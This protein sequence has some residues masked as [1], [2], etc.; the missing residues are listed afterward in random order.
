MSNLGPGIF[1]FGLFGGVIL[2]LLFMVGRFLFW[3][4]RTTDDYGNQYKWS[5][6]WNWNP[7]YW[8]WDV[9]RL[10]DGGSRHY[11]RGPLEIRK[12]YQHTC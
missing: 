12:D 5:L 7:R 9:D 1:M 2:I 8:R 11:L 10:L 3:G 6:W 4:R